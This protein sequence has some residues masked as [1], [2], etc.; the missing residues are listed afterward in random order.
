MLLCAEL[1]TGETGAASPEEGA[2]GPSRLEKTGQTRV[3]AALCGILVL[4]AAVGGWAFWN[5]D[6]HRT[7]FRAALV[8]GDPHE[9]PVLLRRYGCAGCHTISGVPGAKGRV[10]PSLDDVGQRVFLAGRFP[11]TPENLVRWIQEPRAMDP[12]TAM[13]ETGISPGEAQNVAAYLL[14]QSSW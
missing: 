1:R 10:G 3:L 11:N 12:R 6:R 7:E 13:P 8:A 14:Q 5:T 2:E 4:A 9:A